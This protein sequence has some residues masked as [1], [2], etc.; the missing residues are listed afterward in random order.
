[1]IYASPEDVLQAFG[2]EFNAKGGVGFAP[3]E[4]KMGEFKIDDT[5]TPDKVRDSYVGFLAELEKP[6]RKNWSLIK[7]YIMHMAVLKAKEQQNNDV[8]W[9]GWKATGFDGADVTPG[10]F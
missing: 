9:L 4:M 8:A 10:T 5:L 3:W 1:S 2:I 7:W 6:E